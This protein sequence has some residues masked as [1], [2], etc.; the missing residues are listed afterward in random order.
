MFQSIYWAHFPRHMLTVLASRFY[1]VQVPNANHIST[2]SEP[3]RKAKMRCD[4]NLPICQNCRRR[5][6]TEKCI[7]VEAPQTR[8][9]SQRSGSSVPQFSTFAQLTPLENPLTDGSSRT[10]QEQDFEDESSLF[11]ISSGFYGPTSFSAVYENDLGPNIDT[12]QDRSPHVISVEND[13]TE[14]QL[15]ARL[16]CGVKILNQLPNQATCDRIMDIYVRKGLEW[17]FHKPTIICCMNSLW[18]HFGQA[19][20]QPR[21]SKD[22]RE[23]AQLLSRNTMSVLRDTEDPDTW[24]TSLSGRNLRWEMLGIIF[25]ILGKVLLVLPEDDS[26]WSSQSGRR[27]HRKDFTLEMKECVDE[28]IKLSNQTDN[29]NMLLVIVL[30]KRNILES[31]CTGDTSGYTLCSLKSAVLKIM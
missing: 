8:P 18:T 1:R 9:K 12:P 26:F 7:Y 17:G 22:L 5:N 20:R 10:P 14:E 25:C 31:Q 16:S 6:I 3:C 29:I 28:C 15:S 23:I 19:L 13:R 27:M 4:H 2:D 30:F 21:K 11:R 24:L